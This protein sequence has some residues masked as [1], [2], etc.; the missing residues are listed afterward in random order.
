MQWLLVPY[1]HVLQLYVIQIA[2]TIYVITTLH[3]MVISVTLKQYKR[4]FT[5]QGFAESLQQLLNIVCVAI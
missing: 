3:A 1:S 4:P 2:L 5:L